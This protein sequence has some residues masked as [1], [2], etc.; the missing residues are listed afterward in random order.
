M[1]AEWSRQIEFEEDFCRE[2][3]A[4][5]LE[6]RVQLVRSVKLASFDENPMPFSL[7]ENDHVLWFRIM[8]PY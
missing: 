8:P 2:F 3:E 5:D 1:D 6:I 4:L 7:P